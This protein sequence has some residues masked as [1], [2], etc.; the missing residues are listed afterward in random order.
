MW[1]VEQTAKTAPDGRRAKGNRY[2]PDR[3]EQPRRA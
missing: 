1:R 2:V 3:R